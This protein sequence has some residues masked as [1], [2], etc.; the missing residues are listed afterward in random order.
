MRIFVIGLLYFLTTAS[1]VFAEETKPFVPLHET[2]QALTDISFQ[3]ETGSPLQLSDWRGKIVLLN[4][5]ATW[6]GPCREEMP[7]LDRLQEKLG[8]ERFDV[9]ALSID[10]GGVGVVQEFYDE[11]GLQHLQIRIDPTTRA[12]RAMNVFGLPTTLLIG[13]D[14]K[15]L[16]R[17]VGP[18]EWDAPEAIAFFR[19]IIDKHAN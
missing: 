16:G 8:G 3:D 4:V 6:C 15:E 1:A 12:S 17:K 7:T 13:P 10:R 2:P 14:G 9:L 18:A 11:I 19:N 5:W